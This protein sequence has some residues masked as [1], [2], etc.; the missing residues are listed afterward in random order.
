M[1]L[2]ALI[3]VLDFAFKLILLS[4]RISFVFDPQGESTS[5]SFV[6]LLRCC[7]L[8]W[9][10]AESVSHL[11]SILFQ[12]QPLAV[13]TTLVVLYYFALLQVWHLIVSLLLNCPFGYQLSVLWWRIIRWSLTLI[14][15]PLASCRK[16]TS[17]NIFFKS[18]DISSRDDR[19]IESR[20]CIIVAH[21]LSSASV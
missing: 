6:R 7:H 15:Q 18:C 2:T 21:H 4:Q 8:R 11:G 17:I 3:I 9:T 5:A 14:L 12:K 1:D 19:V 10:W 16:Q 20:S 13:Y